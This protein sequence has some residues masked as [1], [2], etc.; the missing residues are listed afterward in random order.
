MLERIDPRLLIVLGALLF[1]TGGAA[2]KGTTLDGWQVAAFRS[3]VAFV[4]L[5]VF[6]PAARR[7]WSLRLVPVAFAYAAML[8][9][10]VL[11]NK[12]TTAANTIFLQSTAPLYVLLLGPLLLREPVHRRDLVF[13]FVVAVGLSLF[14]VSIDTPTHTAPS[15]LAGNL[16]GAL[17]GF[18]WAL[19]LL[20]LRWLAL[21]PQSGSP[22]AAAA[23]GNLVAFVVGAGFAFPVTS[24]VAADWW[25]IGYL[26]VV[27]IGLAY[28]LLTAAIHRVR[29]LEASLLILVEPV[30]N[31]VWAFL[32]LGEIPGVLAVIGGAIILT[33][34]IVRTLR[35]RTPA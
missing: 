34:T 20:G 35:A 3:G 22:A 5:V 12:L 1:S 31:P 9:C 18:F 7:G 19:T 11:G 32:L 21:E 16:L 13:L 15:P 4:A 26:G 29:A 30:F 24:S 6:V 27:Q 2:V 33:A 23:M 14:F 28:V 10:F 8:T 25:L 17:A